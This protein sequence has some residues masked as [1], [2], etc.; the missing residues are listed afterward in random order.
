MRDHDQ[1]RTI[2]RR[3]ADARKQ[4]GLSGQLLAERLG[5][6][7]ETLVNFE[8]GRR[9]ITVERLMAIAAALE[10]HPAALFFDDAAAGQLAA[11]IA[12]DARL[13]AHVR[14]FVASLEDEHDAA[15]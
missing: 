12:T 10:L 5:W 6:A 7:R 14:F 11:Q 15:A 8:L 2:G 9:A 13:S 4:R 1:S 3:I